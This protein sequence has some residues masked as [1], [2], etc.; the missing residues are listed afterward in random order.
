MVF[1][2]LY[3]GAARLMCVGA[4]IEAAVFREAEYLFEEARYLFRLH[5]EGAEALDARRVNDVSAIGQL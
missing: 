2:G 5:I 4:I 1:N 3:H